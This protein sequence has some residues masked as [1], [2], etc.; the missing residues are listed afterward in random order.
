MKYRRL[1][2]LVLQLGLLS[3]ASGFVLR[4]LWDYGLSTE[5]M[6]ADILFDRGL[7]AL[8]KGMLIGG[9]YIGIPVWLALEKLG[10]G[11][12]TNDETAVDG[13]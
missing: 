3:A 6:T 10:P 11:E 13:S 8:K 9:L 12:E 2:K 1:L 5:G 7:Y 4:Y